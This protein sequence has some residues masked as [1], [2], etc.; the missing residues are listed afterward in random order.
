ME[1]LIGKG[2]GLR[3]KGGEIGITMIKGRPENTLRQMCIP[4]IV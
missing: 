1:E 4:H 2:Q 3:K